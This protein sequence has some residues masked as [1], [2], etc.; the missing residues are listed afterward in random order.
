MIQR[1]IDGILAYLFSLLPQFSYFEL[2][3]GLVV[4]SVALLVLN[5]L[6]EIAWRAAVVGVVGVGALWA[7]TQ[8]GLL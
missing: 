8:F 7:A 2:F 6:I 4:V 1:V 5:G 3:A